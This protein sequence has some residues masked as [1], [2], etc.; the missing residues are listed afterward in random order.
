MTT[1][2]PKNTWIPLSVMVAVVLFVLGMFGLVWKASSWTTKTDSRLTS[3]ESQLTIQADKLEEISSKL[4]T[5]LAQY[6]KGNK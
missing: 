2:D 3:I 6:E 5:K 4:D 1:L